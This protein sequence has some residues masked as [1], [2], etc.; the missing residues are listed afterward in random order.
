MRIYECQLAIFR[1]QSYEANTLALKKASEAL[2]FNPYDVDLQL[3]LAKLR[4]EKQIVD[5]YAA[6]EAQIKA[7]LHWL[8]VGDKALKE[9]FQALRACHTNIGIK[10]IKYG[11]D[12]LSS[13]PDI[14]KAL[15]LHYEN[16]FA[17]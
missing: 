17:S 2:T 4:H 8:E 5:N 10:K 7:R 6:R 1:K 16:V 3:Q 9:F 12:V 14:L 11:T 13:L 15:V